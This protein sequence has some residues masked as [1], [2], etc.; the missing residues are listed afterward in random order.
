MVVTIPLGMPKRTLLAAISKLIDEAE[1]PVVPKSKKAKRPLAAQRLRSKPLF[2][3]ITLLLGKAM[4]PRATLWQLGVKAKVSP[5]NADGL[6]IRGP[7][8]ADNISQ[9]QVMAILTSRAMRNAKFVAENAARGDFPSKTTRPLV[10]FDW[11]E[12]YERIS[13]SRPKLKP[14]KRPKTATT[15]R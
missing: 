4:Y 1:V 10:E 2:K 9:R 15:A 7:K 3:Y 5:T 6:D 13:Q 8:T 14:R 11:D 12:I